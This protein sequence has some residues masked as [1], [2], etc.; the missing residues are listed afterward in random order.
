MQN[1]S[2][3]WQKNQ[4]LHVQKQGYCKLSVTTRYGETGAKTKMLSS[5][6]KLTDIKQIKHK[7]TFDPVS[8]ALPTNTLSFTLYNYD[9]QYDEWYRTY[10][11]YTTQIEVKYGYILDRGNEEIPGGIFYVTKIVRKENRTVTVT[12]GSRL[13]L[14]DEVLQSNTLFTIDDTKTIYEKGENDEALGE[15]DESSMDCAMIVPHRAGEMIEDI[16]SVNDLTVSIDAKYRDKPFELLRC[17]EMVRLKTLAFLLNWLQA[18]V[19]LNRDESMSIHEGNTIYF[20][21]VIHNLNIMKA[22]MYEMANKVSSVTI[23]ENKYRVSNKLTDGAQVTELDFVLVDAD[24]AAGHYVRCIPFDYT[25]NALKIACTGRLYN[26][27]R[28]PVVKVETG[29][30]YPVLPGYP[31]SGLELE[32]CIRITS[33]NLTSSAGDRCGVVVYSNPIISDQELKKIDFN[34]KGGVICDISCAFIPPENPEAFGQRLGNYFAN[35]DLY[36]L[37]MRADP[38]RDVGDY[39]FAELEPGVFSKVLI[40][41]SELTF[42]GSFSEK[43]LVRKI[44]S[45]FE[46]VAVDNVTPTSYF[47]ISSGQAAKYTGT[48][49]KVTVPLAVTALGADLFKDKVT[50][51]SCTMHSLVTAV[52][53]NCFNGCTRLKNI[54]I[55]DSVT[56]LGENVFKGCSALE[57]VI[58]PQGLKTVSAGTFS[59]CGKLTDVRLQD[60]AEML[61]TRA[62][63]RCISL[64]SIKLP[65]F[66]TSIGESCFENSGLTEVFIPA[67]V[68]YIRNRCFA[69]CENLTKVSMSPFTRRIGNEAFLG[70]SKLEEI[71]LENVGTI[72]KDAFK[73]CS[74]LKRVIMPQS[75][76]Y[77]VFSDAFGSN[78]YTEGGFNGVLVIKRGSDLIGFAESNGFKYEIID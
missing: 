20:N 4:A 61:E 10:A 2:Y 57:D 70:C 6:D 54:I 24:K 28:N 35:R 33:A 42:E 12:A 5:L 65:G 60:K 53:D 32:R 75:T 38:A 15:L 55:P 11:D 23:A 48:A 39:V 59:N 78:K 67:G 52:G 74:S 13:D 21:S 44:A 36:T 31:T 68:G 27:P 18:K 19:T 30:F 47:T 14:L 34:A 9:N 66:L 76:R 49:A 7:R 45:D 1:V 25:K 64:K 63:E 77:V 16:C 17:F 29:M 41:E 72:E 56:A 62:F 3:E 22:P 46:T 8:I 26:V 40:L 50:L 69:Y 58:L 71:S 37:T 73:N 43:T 51:N